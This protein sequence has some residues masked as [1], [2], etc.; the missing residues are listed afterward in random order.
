MISQTALEKRSLWRFRAVRRFVYQFSQ[1]LSADLQSDSV[2]EPDPCDIIIF[3]SRITSSD[4]QH[5]LNLTPAPIKQLSRVLHLCACVED[6][7]LISRLW[8]YIHRSQTSVSSTKKMFLVFFG[9]NNSFGGDFLKF[10]KLFLWQNTQK[11]HLFSPKWQF[12][13][14]PNSSYT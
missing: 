10:E 12:S 14:M 8:L 4:G 2:R 5:C 7:E 6:C 1:I 11:K 9:S 13:F 3:C